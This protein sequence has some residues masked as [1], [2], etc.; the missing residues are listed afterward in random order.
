M[1]VKHIKNISSHEKFKYNI[2]QKVHMKVY[3]RVM[4]NV[5]TNVNAE[6]REI[7]AHLSTKW[8]M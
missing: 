5:K 2:M 3:R 6:G 4:D 1:Y 7:L 8:T